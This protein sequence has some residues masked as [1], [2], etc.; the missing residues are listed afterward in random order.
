MTVATSR[1]V[2]VASSLVISL[3]LGIMFTSLPVAHAAIEV[4]LYPTDDAYVDYYAP[5]DNYGA[6][7]E[8]IVAREAPDIE[9]SCYLK[10]DL[11]GIPVL[12]TITSA[13][14]ELC[15]T[16]QAPSS[17]GPT[18]RVDVHSSPD[19]TWSE[20]DITWDNAPDFSTTA[21]DD[22]L[23]E[24]TNHFYSW[25]VTDD[26]QAALNARRLTLVLRV[27]GGIAYFYSKEGTVEYKPKLR[28]TYKER[29]SISCSVF[30]Q[31]VVAGDP[32][33]T[34]GS[35]D[36]A[37]PGATVTLTYTEP[38]GVSTWTM[39]VPCVVDSGYRFV[40]TPT[41]VGRWSVV[42]S[43]EGT[44]DY[45]GDESPRVTFW[46]EEEPE[47]TSISCSVTPETVR[48]GENLVV[49]GS[50]YPAQAT[51]TL[52]Y[53]RPDASTITRTV[54]TDS[55]GAY[56]DTYTP[57]AVGRWSVR[58]S[59]EGDDVYAAGM[60]DIRWFTVLYFVTISVTP[61]SLISGEW[62][63]VS[64]SI[65]PA[66]GGKTVVLT[67][68]RPDGTIMGNAPITSSDGSYSDT[69]PPIDVGTW[70]V[71]ARTDD[72]TSETVS[73]TVEESPP[74]TPLWERSYFGLPLYVWVLITIPILIIGAGGVRVIRVR[75]RAR[76]ITGLC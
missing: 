7:E 46:V 17:N 14:F 42:A 5:D 36:P 52:T 51:V 28:V 69:F 29:S 1:R 72:S 49:S 64:G 55:A 15:T 71:Y 65:S 19:N 33:T 39:D 45:V 73:F 35:I 68:Q 31:T 67:Y 10:F 40:F 44:D 62:V 57:D 56:S 34:S 48:F 74:P 3:V 61:S 47:S 2:L 66:Q 4:E 75:R 38:D 25:S 9:T 16:I 18:V 6:S 24:Q 76:R 21:T 54:T 58:A 12:A 53:T 26:A 30:P 37:H 50:I 20:G 60:S 41:V 43:W 27:P 22:Q 63:T 32:L 11:S 13:E 59:W 23:V 8:L 70:S